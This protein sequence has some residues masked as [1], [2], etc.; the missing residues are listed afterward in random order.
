MGFKNIL[1][2]ASNVKDKIDNVS[3]IK[4][5]FESKDIKEIVKTFLSSKNKNTEL[6]DDTNLFKNGFVN[7]LFALEIVTFIEKTFKVKLSKSDI[8][9]ENFETV[10]KICALVERLLK[11]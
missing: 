10:N 11:K 5:A 9:K 7:S 6:D 1:K 8:S 2:K 4:Q 3:E